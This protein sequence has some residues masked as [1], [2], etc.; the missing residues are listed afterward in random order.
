MSVCHRFL[1]LALLF[2][3]VSA[4]N[5]GFFSFLHQLLFGSAAASLHPV[6][7]DGTCCIHKPRV[8]GQCSGFP[9]SPFSLLNHHPPPFSV[10]LRENMSAV[11][12]LWLFPA[13]TCEVG[14]CVVMRVGLVCV[15]CC[16]VSFFPSWCDRRAARTP[17][18]LWFHELFYKH[19]KNPQT[20][21][22]TRP[23]WLS[24][25]FFVGSC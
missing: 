8:Q 23:T 2:C 22:H 15:L 1:S 14:G 25:L 24:D 18:T 13:C 4:E 10:Q 5:P 11:L 20:H 9:F 16:S 7:C 3:P 19:V 6:A 21:Q 12:P 17:R